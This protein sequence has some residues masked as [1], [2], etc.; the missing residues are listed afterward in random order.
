MCAKV[1]RA[2][3]EQIH[4]Q[5]RL[6]QPLLRDGPR[7]CG[8]FRPASWEEALDAVHAGFARV[9]AHHGSEAIAPLFYGGPMGLLAN[10]SMDR[11]FFHRLGASRVDTSPLCAGVTS[12]AWNSV[13][14][15]VGGIPFSELG[16]ANP[17]V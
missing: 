2:L 6:L 16:K 17:G 9:R 4:G 1:A 15:D 3:P 13:F 11:R 7:G 8:G 5:G 10:G 12:A 14:G